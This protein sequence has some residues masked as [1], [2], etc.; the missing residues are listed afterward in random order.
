MT[1]S[2]Q[3]G[4]RLITP[5]APFL[6]VGAMARDAVILKQG[7]NVRFKRFFRRGIDRRND[8]LVRGIGPGRDRAKNENEGMHVLAKN[9]CG[10]GEK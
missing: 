4:L 9:A 8:R 7:P 3:R 6:F 2:G 10:V 5:Q 1:R